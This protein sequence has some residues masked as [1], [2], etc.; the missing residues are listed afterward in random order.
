MGWFLFIIRSALTTQGVIVLTYTDPRKTLFGAKISWTWDVTAVHPVIFS[1]N[2][3]WQVRLQKENLILA[4]NSPR[5][6]CY[7]SSLIVHPIILFSEISPRVI[8]SSLAF[9]QL[10]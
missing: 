4:Y 8:C 10:C 6:T 7:S 9:S 2:P 3:L 1:R 5:I